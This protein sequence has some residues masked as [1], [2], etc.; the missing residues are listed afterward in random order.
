MTARHAEL[1]ATP[2]GGVAFSKS[3]RGAPE[4]IARIAATPSKDRIFFYPYMP[5][6]PFL[7]MRPQT[8]KYDIFTPGYTSPAQYKEACL[9][10][11]GSAS[12]VVMDTKWTDPAFCEPFFPRCETQRPKRRRNLNV[13]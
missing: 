6:M 12:W 4:L 1:V 11:I 10:A 5:L 2:R 13:L 8:S 7:T 9:S 3:Q